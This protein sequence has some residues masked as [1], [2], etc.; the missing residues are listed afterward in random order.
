MY[1]YIPFKKREIEAE[2]QVWR[3]R[4]RKLRYHRCCSFHWNSISAC[5]A[6]SA[7]GAWIASTSGDF[8]SSDTRSIGATAERWLAFPSKEVVLWCFDDEDD[9]RDDGNGCWDGEEDA[10]GGD[11]GWRAFSLFL[12]VFWWEILYMIESTW[13]RLQKEPLFFFFLLPLGEASGAKKRG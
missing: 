3:G 11:E 1:T 8:E 13:L 10:D 4:G 2:A 12:A 9:E 6:A 5:L 7:V